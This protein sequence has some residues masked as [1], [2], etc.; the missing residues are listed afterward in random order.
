MRVIRKALGLLVVDIL[1]IVGIFVLQ[2]RT[3]STIIKKIGNLQAT[4]SKSD[5]DENELK[6][7]LL[8]TYNG[9]N[10]QSDDQLCA[11]AIFTDDP[12]ARDILLLNY[13]EEDLKLTFNFSDDINVVFM[14][15]EDAP[16][17]PLT[18]FADVPKTVSDFYLPFSFSYN[19]TVEKDEG[20][21]II[22][23]GKKLVWSLTTDDITDQYIHFTYGDNIA[24]Y[25]IYDN[26]TKFTFD[27][28]TELASAQESV[29]NNTIASVK[30]NMLSAFKSSINDNS[31]TEQAVVAYI[32]EMAANGKYQ[33]AI[34][35]IPQSYKKSDSRTYLSAPFLNN[36]SAMNKKLENNLDDQN[37]L[38][39][40]AADSGNMDIFTVNNIAFYLSI[41]QNP[42]TV[43]KILQNVAENGIA[44]CTISQITGILSTYVELINYNKDYAK[45][46]TPIMESCIQKITDACSYENDILAISEKDTFL[47]VVQAVQ[48]G[49]AILRYGNLIN[50][51]TYVKAGRVIIN[52]YIAESSSFD[53]RT[54]SNIYQLIAYNNKYYPRFVILNSSVKSTCWAW[55]IADDIKYTKEADGGI[56]LSIDFPEGLT[57]YVIFK[58][59]PV[60]EQIFI[61]NM[62][63]RTD[64]RFETY[65]SSGYVYKLDTET[66]LLKSRHKSQIEDIKLSYTPVPKATPK[67]AE[68]PKPAATTEAPKTETPAATAS[69]TEQDGAKESSN[70][71]VSTEASAQ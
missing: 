25:S 29:Y 11:K 12:I 58:G 4:L 18:V 48:T 28:I 36:L 68:T 2:F 50:N 54:L 66:L 39:N 8:V 26:V 38:I 55:T 44:E 3:D 41:Y 10:F 34:D 69:T 13:S 21:K 59:I 57:H 63:F 35:E 20:N 51:E 52:S 22:L 60:F 42:S 6:N 30:A 46:L 5:S 56:T 71:T 9:I 40:K 61:Y 70:S 53:L 37:A 19:M 24:K 32:A 47:S 1:I 16:E 62:S 49:V 43:R 33:Q 27:S 7:K 17:A 23:N 14:L 65:N 45:I 15:A 64:P 67:P 31:F